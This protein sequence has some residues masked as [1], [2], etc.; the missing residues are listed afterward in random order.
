MEMAIG[1]HGFEQF[2]SK[3]K[4]M[5]SRCTVCGALSVPPRHL[6]R[7]GHGPRMQWVQMSG[8]GRL[9][10]FTC[11]AIGPPHMIEEGYDRKNPYC[12]G[13][14]ELDEGPRVVARL[15]GVN[16]LQPESIEIGMPLTVTFL[17]RET[18]QGRRTYL[19]F[20]PPPGP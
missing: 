14:V 10:A 16:A 20:T 17:H 19:A 6:C 11:I 8:S 2:L 18:D 1:S 7:A 5:G 13:V 15:E 3:E 9:A 12:C 4:L